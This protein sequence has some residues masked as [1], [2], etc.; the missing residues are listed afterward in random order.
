MFVFSHPDDA[1]IFAGGT[2]ARLVAD[3]KEVAVVKMSMGNK[4]S[5]QTKTTE[6]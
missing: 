6:R 5:G 1:E 2:I 4:G 3:K